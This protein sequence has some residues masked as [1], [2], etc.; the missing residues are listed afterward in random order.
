MKPAIATLALVLGARALL[1]AAQEDT[2][3]DILARLRA[4]RAATD[5][6]ASGRLVRVTGAEQRTTSQFTM[7]A[8]AFPGVLKLFCSITDSGA[9]RVRLLLES[10]LIAAG[11][12]AASR[13]RVGHPGDAAA[14][15][16]APERWGEGVL[17]SDFTYEDLLEDQFQWSNQSIKG[18]EKCG[19]RDC[20]ILVSEPGPSDRSHYSSVTS[21]LARDILYPVRAEKIVR[22]SGIVKE[23]TYFGLRESKGVWSASQ[24]EVKIKDKPGSTLLIIN[25][26]AEKPNLTAQAFD[27]LLL[28][29]P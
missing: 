12:R 6:K 5:F 21:W 13:I 2:L 11:A 27:P 18:R 28:I 4:A 17:E 9:A 22:G 23:F 19:A 10:P 25:R 24:V 29:K 7:Q 3:A 16:L 20:V 1:P 26:G 14:R 8:H 15:D